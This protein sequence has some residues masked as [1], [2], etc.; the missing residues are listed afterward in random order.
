MKLPS[1]HLYLHF[2]VN[3]SRFQGALGG[4]WVFSCLFG[5]FFFIDV[6]LFT[7]HENVLVCYLIKKKKV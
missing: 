4:D 1:V 3:I 7:L 5:V 6:A 2:R